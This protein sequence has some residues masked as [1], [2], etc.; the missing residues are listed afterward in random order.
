MTPMYTYTYTFKI[1]NDHLFQQ[2]RHNTEDFNLFTLDDVDA[3]FDKIIQLKYSQTISL[4]GKKT[5][6]LL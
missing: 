5:V 1:V 6:A 4:K 3:A 2:S